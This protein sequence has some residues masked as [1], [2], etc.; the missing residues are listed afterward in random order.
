MSLKCQKDSYLK[1]FQTRVKSC[2]PAKK[3]LLVEGKKTSVEGYNIILE[4]SILFPE[5]GGQPDDRGTI[6]DIPVLSISRSG[7]D[8]V[9]FTKT[10][11]SVGSEVTL[12]LDWDRR[13]EFMQQHTAQHLIT[14][15]AD[16]KFGFQTTSWDIGTDIVTIELDTP[17]I[18]T[19]QLRNIEDSANESLRNNV[20]VGPSFYQDK[21]D[22][23]LKKFRGLGLPDD[24]VGVVRVLTIE[25][26]DNALCCGTHVSNLSHIQAIKIL[27]AEKGKKSKMNLLF[28]AGVRLLRYS[29]NTYSREKTLTGVLKGPG[30]K[31]C[32]LAEKAVKSFKTLQKTCTTQSR[33]IATLEAQLYKQ[34]QDKDTVFVKHRKD[35]DNDYVTVLIAE[36]ADENLPKLVT[37][38]DDKDGG[39]F[40][41]A[42]PQILIQ[43]LG[44]KICEVFHGKGAP[45]KG[46]F[47]GKAPKPESQRGKAESLLREYVANQ[48]QRQGENGQGD[49]SRQS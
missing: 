11:I 41:L 46:L 14:A 17:S 36:L 45:S 42:G 3:T 33:E 32:E 1:E 34:A 48:D 43:E 26:I 49:S 2:T 6:N 44:P 30:E 18:T 10:E 25:G 12:Q 31:H 7:E 28:L 20:S 35:G 47:R 8:A 22:P 29:A 27:G 4:D 9:H 40:V 5:G 37:T 24:H 38:G 23:E 15:M 13:F 21:D 19:E 16:H 39:M